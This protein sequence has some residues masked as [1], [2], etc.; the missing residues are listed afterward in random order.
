MTENNRCPSPIEVQDF[1]FKQASIEQ[2]CKSL[3]RL[4]VRSNLMAA[5]TKH[6]LLY[7]GHDYRL[8]VVKPGNDSNAE[9]K[10]ELKIPGVAEHVQISCDCSFLAVTFLGASATIYDTSSISKHRLDILHEIRLSSSAGN[11][12]VSDLKWNPAIPEMFCSVTSDHTIGC[13]HVNKDKKVGIQI[14]GMERISGI[15]AL[16]VSWSPKGKQLVVGCKNGDIIQLKPDLKPARQLSGPKPSR[17]MIISILWV[18]NYQFCTCYYQ[19][20]SHI[21]V[22]IVDAPKGVTVPKFTDYEDITYGYGSSYELW[23]YFDHVPEWGLIIAASSHSTEVTVLGSTDNGATWTTWEMV[24]GGTVQLPL[25]RKQGLENYPIGMAI[26]RSPTQRLT[27]SADNTL[28]IPVPILRILVTSGQ[29]CSYHMVNLKEEAPDICSPPSEVIQAPAIPRPSMGPEVSFN[30]PSGATS[31]PHTTKTLESKQEEAKI[32]NMFGEPGIPSFSSLAPSN[33]A[34]EP[35]LQTEIKNVGFSAPPEIKTGGLF[36]PESVKTNLF[37]RDNQTPQINPQ[38]KPTLGAQQ[39]ATGFATKPELRSEPQ[40]TQ[41]IQS[42]VKVTKGPAKDQSPAAYRAEEAASAAKELPVYDDAL[43]LRAYFDEQYKFE[44]ELQSKLDLPNWQVG[45]DEE[46]DLL[47]KKSE[48]IDEFLRE[49]RDTTNSLASDIAYLKALLLQSFAW[50]EESKSKNSTAHLGGRGRTEGTKFADL[51]RLYYYT[52][53]Q[54]IQATKV[55]DLEWAEHNNRELTRMKIPSL[56]VIYQS[57]FRHSQIIAQEKKNIEELSKKWRSLARGGSSSLASLDR[58]MASL[59]LSQSSSTTLI[60]DTA[61]DLRCKLIASNIRN[62][63][64]EKQI[65]LR[66]LLAETAPMIVRAVRPSAVQDRL[67]ATLSALAA[68]KPIEAASSKT[69]TPKFG[70]T[71]QQK[72]VAQQ[73]L[74]DLAESK[75]HNY[76]SSLDNLVSGIGS[77]MTGLPSLSKSPSSTSPFSAL[78]AK[79]QLTPT[80]SKAKENASPLFSQS[81]RQPLQTTLA[82]K[83]FPKIDTISFN[84]TQK[85]PEPQVNKDNLNKTPE[86]TGTFTMFPPNTFGRLGSPEALQSGTGAVI[87]SITTLTTVPKATFS[88]SSNTVAPSTPHSFVAPKL[89]NSSVFKF[90]SNLSATLAQ[91]SP[92]TSTSSDLS[93]LNFGNHSGLTITPISNA[94]TTTSAEPAGLPTFAFGKTSSPQQQH[95]I[96][97]QSLNVSAALTPTMPSLFGKSTAPAILT[98][99]TVSS[100]EKMSA[101]STTAVA[102]SAQAAINMSTPGAVTVSV[103]AAPTSN[104]PSSSSD[105]GTSSLFAGLPAA[106]PTFN[107]SATSTQATPSTFTQATTATTTTDSSTRISFQNLSSTA[108]S[109]SSGFAGILGATSALS[110]GTSSTGTSIT[111]IFGTTMTSGTNTFGSSTPATTAVA[112][113][114]TSAPSISSIFGKSTSNTASPPAAHIFGGTTAGTVSTNTTTSTTSLFSS[115]PSTGTTS[116]FG[117]QTTVI[118]SSTG[119]TENSLFGVKSTATTTATTAIPTAS[120]LGSSATATT[121]TP[122]ASLFGGSATVTTAASPGSIFGGSTTATTA[123]PTASIFGGS[124]TA[125]TATPTAPIFGSN[126]SVTPNTSIFGNSSTPGFGAA[127]KTTQANVFEGST[128]PSSSSVFGSSSSV[129]ATGS[130]FGGASSTPV[131]GVSTTAV[132]NNPSSGIFGSTPASGSMFGGGTNAGTIATTGS[133]VF[134]AT[135]TASIFGGGATVTTTASNTSIFGGTATVTTPSV[136]GVNASSPTTGGIFGAAATSPTVAGTSSIFGGPPSLGAGTSAF[137]GAASPG[138]NMGAAPV[139][140]GGAAF[141]GA[142][143][144]GGKP[145]FGS[146]GGSSFGSGF[147]SPTSFGGTATAAGFGRTPVFG[148]TSPSATSNTFAELGAQQGGLSFGSLAQNTDTQKPSFTGSS[149][150]SSWR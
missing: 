135:P 34:S 115:T 70:T 100:Q 141:G 46:R 12:F 107:L 87:T 147:G 118:N 38:F 109:S 145:V 124:T 2:I 111:P 47:V 125:T 39:P 86:S 150:F 45:T 132:P 8:I 15:D 92:A 54:L 28:P 89:D 27:L 148:S 60:S 57:L 117:G 35:P 81:S 98:A 133:S 61:I 123:T 128:A 14:V 143:A 90:S 95:S 75:T 144:F 71:D 48:D 130:I 119:N 69:R 31:T 33:K 105:F 122:T 52:Q 120:L 30:L 102:S 131:F 114:T 41:V 44:K 76:L 24:E 1:L 55:L 36:T 85:T 134:G 137:G 23:Y 63:T 21:S 110:F 66:D 25:D 65:K 40:R 116:M 4:P 106:S 68:Q 83:S 149:S 91:P 113:A 9:W 74:P 20:K 53:S 56:E 32:S 6:G 78:A 29:L 138:G 146:P 82:N 10:L 64:S 58:S 104:T 96:F 99:T 67:E 49:L 26:D 94:K 139:F 129:P 51:Q 121:A 142:P 84:T 22:M 7:I 17:G 136:F 93:S 103:A 101:S 72:M 43:C 112:A 37:Q 140:G 97:G 108:P 19:D 13:F 80:Q 5:D 16:C 62:F 11:V 126:I 127:A 42:E 3:P 88:F 50:L 59:N 73:R 77:G 79:P 18:S